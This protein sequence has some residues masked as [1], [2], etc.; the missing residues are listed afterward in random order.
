M[1]PRNSALQIT[2]RLI[3]FKNYFFRS[4]MCKTSIRKPNCYRNIV[5]QIKLVRTA[6]VSHDFLR[7]DTP[8]ESHY[9]VRSSL[10][11]EGF[12]LVLTTRNRRQPSLNKI[13]NLL[14][15]YLTEVCFLLLIRYRP[16]DLSTLVVIRFFIY[17][18][19]LKRMRT[20]L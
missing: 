18:S 9:P 8:L 7:T 10:A 2:L 17:A 11:K 4:Y 12:N 16:Y 1:F 13:R 14:T 6:G 5:I 19:Q 20:S 3:E 15:R